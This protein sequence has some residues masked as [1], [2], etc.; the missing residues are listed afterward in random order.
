MSLELSSEGTTTNR[1]REVTP[2]D[3]VD[4]ITDLNDEKLSLFPDDYLLFFWTSSVFLTVH[5]PPSRGDKQLSFREYAGERRPRVTDLAGNEVGNVCKMFD[6]H[7]THPA[8]AGVHEF[9]ILGRRHIP[10]VPEFPATVLALQIERV[11]GIA[12]RTNYA[13]IEET[14]WMAA[15][16]RETLIALA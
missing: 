6:D 15:G 16:P 14:A 13:E 1:S 11:D 2:Q 7:W 12:Y 4:N 3:I 10:E 8:S 5:A 9:I